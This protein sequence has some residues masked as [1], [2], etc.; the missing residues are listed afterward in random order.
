MDRERASVDHTSD[1]P[2]CCQRD[3]VPNHDQPRVLS[4]LWYVWSPLW[5]ALG[6]VTAIS[7][8][9]APAGHSG[10]DFSLDASQLQAYLATAVITAI[11][12]SHPDEDHYGLL[13]SVFPNPATDL[14]YLTHVVLGGQQGCYTGKNF[15]AWLASLPSKVVVAS[16]NSGNPCAGNCPQPVSA[17]QLCPGATGFQ[18]DILA[19][20]LGTSKNS[21]S[22]LVRVQYKSTSA[23]LPGTTAPAFIVLPL[24]T[25]SRSQRANCRGLRNPQCHC[26][27]HS[28]RRKQ[29]QGRRRPGVP[30]WS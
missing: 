1:R 4:R 28:R 19:A 29:P 18:F 21:Q 17:D 12:V 10:A 16:V 7:T 3:P 13:P 6:H 25:V 14:P 27:C 20:N 26:R 5:A 30:P 9:R 22:A 2:R 23:L 24:W 15:P 11:V 8:H